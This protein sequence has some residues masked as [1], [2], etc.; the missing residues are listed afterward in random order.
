MFY[1]LDENKNAIP[2]SDI[3]YADQM[4]EM[5]KNGNTPHVAKDDIGDCWVS[6]IWLGMSHSYYD[7]PPLLFETMI[8]KDGKWLNYQ[9]RYTTWKEAEE[10]HKTAIEWVKNGCSGEDE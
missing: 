6:T 9:K 3:E 1:K 7:G 2:C 4:K 10:G 8:E 5:L